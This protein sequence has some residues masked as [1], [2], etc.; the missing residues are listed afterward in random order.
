MSL[1][2]T[3]DLKLISS[4]PSIPD[5]RD[6]WLIRT[7]GGHLYDSFSENNYVGIEHDKIS[8]TEF[9]QIVKEF[10]GDKKK[11]V[12]QLKKIATNRYPEDQQPGIIAN[13]IYRFSIELKK[14]D[15]VLIPYYNSDYIKIGTVASDDLII[16]TPALKNITGC[17]FIL[18]KKVIW[19]GEYKRTDL[20]PF[21][22]KI[23]QSHQAI[24]NVTN[25]SEIIERS[26]NNFFIDS[27]EVAHVILNILK[28]D[29]IRARDLFGLGY[30]LLDFVEGFLKHHNLPFNI[31][32]IEVKLTVNSPGKL[33]L[34]STQKT[35]VWIIALST[36][37][38][39]GGG[40][41]LGGGNAQIEVLGVKGDFKL[42]GLV[43]ALNEYKNGEVKRNVANK[44]MNQMDT[45]QVVPPTDAIK[46]INESLSK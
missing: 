25:Y 8:I 24:N 31:D 5:E 40:V 38:V 14:G 2:L 41:M 37:L 43:N 44:L 42:D 45:L 7:Q 10:P 3:E 6:Y 4:I 22:F 23:F 33:Q 15:K 34:S 9:N 16:V 12:D 19:E 26:I 28:E 11:V 27:D 18:R 13:Q 17:N 20:D 32:D 36:M 21:I 30:H 1:S 39:L 35:L 46:I 29:N